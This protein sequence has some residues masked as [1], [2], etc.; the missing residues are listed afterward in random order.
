MDA[1]FYVR[2]RTSHISF[3]SHMKETGDISLERVPKRL[4]I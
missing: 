4:A 1:L 2:T 3:A